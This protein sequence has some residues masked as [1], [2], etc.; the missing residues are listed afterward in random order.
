MIPISDDPGRA[1]IFPFVNI[2]LIL[3]NIAVFVYMVTL[4]EG[5]FEAFVDRYALIPAELVR[6]PTSPSEL[7]AVLTAMFM[8]G[9]LLHIASNMLYLFIF[10]DNVEDAMGHFGYLVFYVLCGI[11]ASVAQILVNPGSSVPN[12]GASGAIAGVLGA[13]LI[14]FPNSGVR[15]LILLPFFP[16][17]LWPRIAAIVVIGLWAIGNIIAGFQT[18]GMPS[19]LAQDV[20]G[21]AYFAHIGGFIA[22]LL[23]ARPFARHLDEARSKIPVWVQRARSPYP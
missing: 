23:F 14:L 15:T 5:R 7:L 17:I 20:G 16:F 1:R 22:G 3:A 10:G 6:N 8:H 2:A 21:V 18:F 11:I 13:Y 4:P 12:V 19:E 9:G